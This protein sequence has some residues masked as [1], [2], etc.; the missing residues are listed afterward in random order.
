MGG[1]PLGTLKVGLVQSL[2]GGI[3]GPERRQVAG[4]EV[5]VPDLPALWTRPWDMYLGEGTRAVPQG[6]LF[7]RE[8]AL[9]GGEREQKPRGGG[10]VVEEQCLAGR[11]LPHGL[12]PS[13]PV[14]VPGL[15]EAWGSSM[16]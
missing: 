4:T 12:W 14:L 15:D 10:N 16:V 11:I 8:C 1:I 13:G 7:L 9:E 3:C 2:R 5:L 6:D